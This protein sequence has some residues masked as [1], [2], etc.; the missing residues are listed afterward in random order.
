M[1]KELKQQFHQVWCVD[2]EFKEVGGNLP[3][4]HCMVARELFSG[5]LICQWIAGVDSALCQIPLGKET[6]YVAYFATAE[7]K[8]HLALGWPLPANVVDLFVEFRCYTNGKALPSGRGLLGALVYF[9]LSGI[10]YAEKEAMR[11]LAIRGAPFNTQ[12]R[13]ELIDYCKSDVDALVALLPHLKNQFNLG[14]ALLRGSYMSAAAVMEYIGIPTDVGTLKLLQEKWEEIKERLIQRVD[15]HYGVY[16]GTTF[17]AERFASYLQ[18]NKI[19]WPLLPSGALDLKDATFRQMAKKHKRLSSLRELRHA[20]GQMRM[21]KFQV[22]KDGRAR[23]SISP[24]R[25]RTGRNQP[26]TTSYIFGSSVWL[27]SL[28]KPSQGMGVAYIDWSQQEIGIAAALSG[29]TAMQAAY[30]SGDPYLEFAKQAGLAPLEA[31]KQSHP[32][33]RKLC[34]AAV[35]AVQYGMGAESLAES[36]DQPT[37]MGR[38]LLNNHRRT[39]PDFWK[40]SEDVVNYALLR[41]RLWT[42]FGWFIHIEGHVNARSL[43]NFPMQANGA[44]ILRL[45]CCYMVTAG[46]RV[47]AP[48][49]D[50]VL[51]EAPLGV[52]EEHVERAREL[53]AKASRDVLGGFELGTD[54]EIIRYPERYCDEDRG[55]EFW[56]MVMD[57]LD[58]LKTTEANGDCRIATNL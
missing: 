30:L 38:E 14:Q 48:V 7:L 37:Q 58:K 28:I 19:P 4:V 41:R 45:A 5:Q 35:L 15:I 22:G 1:T 20:L 13:H 29:D 47:C 39:F 12:E 17:K 18:R 25:S 23:T 31:T 55:R 8:C 26:S 52:L 44:E 53:M 10:A 33:Q 42:T 50:A 16:E 34:K 51:I 43:A 36:I 54:V 27:R 2:F 24:F 9:G 6:L 57:E 11:E 46:I 56:E 3:E 32:E 49:H 21:Q 40:W